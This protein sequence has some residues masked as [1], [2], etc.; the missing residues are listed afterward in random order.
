M[1][2]RHIGIIAALGACVVL[3]G[4]AIY[5]STQQTPQSQKT[6]TEQATQSSSDAK[7]FHA[8]YPLTAINNRFAIS[9]PTTVLEVFE[10]GSG[11]VFL[12]FPSC[13]WCQ[14][15][16]PI[17]DQAAHDENLTKIYYLDIGTA[18]AE[19]NDTYQKIVAKLKDHLKVDEQGNPRVYVPDVTALHNGQIVGRFR[20]EP[21]KEGEQ[22]K[23]AA[24]YWKDSGRRDRAK[25]Q[26]RN[27]IRATRVPKD[28]TAAIQ[29]G[30]QLIDVRTTTEYEQSHISGAI[31]LPLTDLE[32][33][34]KPSSAQ[35]DTPIYVYCRSGNRSSRAAAIL[36]DA[37]YTHVY[38]LGSL[39]DV[40]KLGG[41]VRR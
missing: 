8:L 6:T 39:E 30:A 12:G 15:L 37:G 1:N 20:Q 11:V 10:K 33:G 5:L 25:A 32:K 7:K 34:K 9:N 26:L 18:R 14:Q 28:I 41:T 4:T 29:Q 38:N 35:K 16:A 24:E 13:P 3:I 19:N 36:K 22:P 17:V 31:S 2:K 27:I 23:N 40:E 21:L